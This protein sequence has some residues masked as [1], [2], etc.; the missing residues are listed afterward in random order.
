MYFVYVYEIVLR[1]RRGSKTGELS[2]INVNCLS[3]LVDG[4]FV[5]AKRE[6]NHWLEL[7]SQTIII[8]TSASYFL[9]KSLYR[10]YQMYFKSYIFISKD[11]L[12]LGMVIPIR[13]PSY[14]GDRG[15]RI[16]NWRQAQAVSQTLSQEKIQ[17]KG[18]SV[19]LKW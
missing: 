10:L 4:F 17:T 13:N 9:P 12:K 5:Q 7:L 11:L 3:H 15:R 8:C 18:L 19:W 2:E 14:L 6:K 16:L 1:G